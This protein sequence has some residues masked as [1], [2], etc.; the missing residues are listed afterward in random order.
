MLAVIILLV[1]MPIML[2]AISLKPKS[3]RL[4]KII[5]Y[6]AFGGFYV[7]V[8]SILLFGYLLDHAD[9][10]NTSPTLFFNYLGWVSFIGIAVGPLC[11][12]ISMLIAIFCK[13]KKI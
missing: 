8:A 10:T 13:I 3:P 5:R 2:A 12:V 4:Q 7:F 11:V 1:V 6:L 9:A